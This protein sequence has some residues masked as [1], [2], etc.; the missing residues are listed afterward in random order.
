MIKE[1]KLRHRL[2]EIAAEHINWGRPMVYS[3]LR[4]EGWIVKHKRVQRLLR[5]AGLQ[6]PAPCKQRRAVPADAPVRRHG[7]R[8]QA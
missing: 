3:L 6:R 7:Q 5:E 1:A 4:P 2:W 8:Q